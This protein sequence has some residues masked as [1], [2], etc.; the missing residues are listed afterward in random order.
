MMRRFSCLAHWVGWLVLGCLPEMVLANGLRSVPEH[1]M[2][3]A[4][5]YNFALLTSWPGS[6]SGV[7]NVCVVG[8]DD[9]V[10]AVDVLQ[11]KSVGRQPIQVLQLAQP[12]DAPK[13]HVVF[14]S[15]IEPTRVARLWAAI[16][17]TS[18][19]TVT[20]DKRLQGETMI[21]LE[22]DNQRLVF[23]VNM[24]PVRRAELTL[25]SKLLRLAKRVIAP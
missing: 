17:G 9:Y 8:Q 23:E 11:G 2:K 7:F 19:L 18:V 3:A 25:S 4:Y 6:P 24:V 13:C 12:E 16:H 5:L 20:D 1:E 22:P 14:V 10:A 21:Y 15:D